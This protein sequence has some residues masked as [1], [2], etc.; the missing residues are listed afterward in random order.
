VSAIGPILLVEDDPDDRELTI[1]SLRDSNIANAIDVV[2]DGPEALSYFT[3]LARPLPAVILLED[4][5]TR[6]VP[7]VMLT[8][9]N[10]ESDRQRSYD[11]GANAYVCKPV[12]F[13]GFTEAMRT[14]GLFWLVVNAPPPPPPVSTPGR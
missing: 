1:M 2:R 11:S 5:P 9:S 3:D 10:E 8:S 6:L 14:L 12:D 7:I 4:E 13:E